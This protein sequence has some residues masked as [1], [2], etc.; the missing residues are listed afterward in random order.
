MIIAIAIIAGVLLVAILVLSMLRRQDRVTAIGSLDR[1]A[2]RRDQSDSAVAPL[3]AGEP[4]PVTAAEVER[5]AEVGRGGAGTAVVVAPPPAKPVP[6]PPPYIDDETLGVTRRQF[7]NRS[8][9]ATFGLAVAGFGA[10]A[11]GFLWPPPKGGFGSKVDAG[12]LSDIQTYWR[13]TQAP[14]YVPDARTWLNPYPVEDVPKAKASGAYSD[15]II[16]GYELGVVALYQKCVHLGCRVPW[17]QSSQWFECP[18][19]GSKYNRVGEK[20][21]GPAPRGLDRFAVSVSGGGDV[22]ID[23]KYVPNGP[24][25]G[26]NTTGQEAEGPHCH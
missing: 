18:C 17:C 21:G 22:I 6:A 24:P 20:K 8:I 16:A 11:L 1:D 9:L 7:L 19:H 25:I 3:V 2:R 14:F 12:K 15:S 4:R 23:T 26:T 5:A 13:N 10:A